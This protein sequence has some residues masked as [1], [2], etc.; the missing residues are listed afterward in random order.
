MILQFYSLCQQ[1]AAD[2]WRN[3]LLL[4]SEFSDIVPGVF[5]PVVE[6]TCTR[7][8]VTGRIVGNPYLNPKSG[9]LVGTITE[10]TRNAHFAGLAECKGEVRFP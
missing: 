8:A 3:R 1:A 10:A 6:S 7:S 9:P 5:T 4:G 2:S